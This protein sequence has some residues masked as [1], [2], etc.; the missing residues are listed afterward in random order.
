MTA[1]ITLRARSTCWRPPTFNRAAALA[2][3]AGNADAVAI[4]R[5]ETA[6]SGVTACSGRMQRGANCFTLPSIPGGSAQSPVWPH[7]RARY[8]MAKYQYGHGWLSQW[9]LPGASS[10]GNCL[11]ASFYCAVC[12]TAAIANHDRCIQSWRSAQ[13]F[14]RGRYRGPPLCCRAD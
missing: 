6:R 7:R 12:V 4:A 3:Q 5:P 14:P 13:A 2:L 8:V 10:A 9:A 1:S 11:P